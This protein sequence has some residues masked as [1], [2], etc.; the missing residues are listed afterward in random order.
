MSDRDWTD[1]RLEDRAVIVTGAS[2]GIGR[3]LAEAA[4]EEGAR[5]ALA[6]R[7]I[8]ALKEVAEVCRERGG[9]AI[10]VPT[11]VT[12]EEACKHLVEETVEA[13]GGIDV[14]INNA[15]MTM[16]ASFEDIED[17]DI[18]E[19]IMRVNYLG[20][21]YCTYYALPHLKER[22]GLIVGISSLTGK[23][24]VPTRTAYSASKHAMQGFF[25]SLRIELRGSG[26]E[27]L[28]VSPGYVETPIR[29]RALGPD[30][31]PRGEAPE[32]DDIDAMSLEEC[33]DEIM[34]A[35]HDRDRELVMTL[36]GKLG[37]W[38]K[39]IAPDVLDEVAAR[40][41]QYDE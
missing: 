32:K 25:D 3:A 26:T 38:A 21:V 12:D 27:V 30:G 6:A 37:Q 18:F 13:F 40:S 16:R 11:D 20:A 28:V 8:E 23:T 10:V 22:E 5:V 17:L 2:S 41:V 35:I 29:E 7:S 19:R 33:T 1:Y 14:L 4:A 24:G 36:K 34:D 15:G 9:E 31:E 39:L